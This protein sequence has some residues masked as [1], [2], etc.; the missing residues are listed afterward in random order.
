MLIESSGSGYP[1]LGSVD[2]GGGMICY[3]GPGICPV[4]CRMFSKSMASVRDMPVARTHPPHAPGVTIYNVSRQSQKSFW[5]SKGTPWTYK[6]YRPG[7]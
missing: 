5:R 3:W 2:I 1:N 7:W 6:V 4:H